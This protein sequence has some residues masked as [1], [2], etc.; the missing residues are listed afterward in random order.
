MF[1]SS[2]KTYSFSRLKEASI[3]KNCLFL[4]KDYNLFIHVYF[5]IVV[6]SLLVLQSTYI[7]S[8]FRVVLSVSWLLLELAP[9]DLPFS[10]LFLSCLELSPCAIKCPRRKRRILFGQS[11][12]KLSTPATNHRI[13]TN[14]KNSIKSI[15]LADIFT[16]W[17]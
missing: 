14:K 9:F 6:G 15:P 8:P 17:Q 1:C 7:Y 5:P 2:I 4:Q 16:L 3:P 13:H 12:P 10:L 11:M